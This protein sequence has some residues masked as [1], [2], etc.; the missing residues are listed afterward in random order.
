[1]FFTLTLVLNEV[2]LLLFVIN[3]MQVIYDEIPATSHVSGVYT[4]AAV[5][6]LKFMAH[7]MLFPM[8]IIII[9]IRSFLVAISKQF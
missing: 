8:T 3:F 2:L 7:V 6:Y 9:I 1:M 4:F 5:M